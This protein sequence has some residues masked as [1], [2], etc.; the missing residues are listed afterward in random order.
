MYKGIH[1][2]LLELN[3]LQREGVDQTDSYSLLFGNNTRVVEMAK[4]NAM[5]I[6]LQKGRFYLSRKK[7]KK[8]DEYLVID[9][10]NG[11]VYKI[12][13]KFYTVKVVDDNIQ[14][15][16]NRT[17][18]EHF[19]IIESKLD[20]GNVRHLGINN[21]T[22]FSGDSSRGYRGVPAVRFEN[23]SADSIRVHWIIALIKWGILTLN[24]CVGNSPTHKLRHKVAHIKSKNNSIYNLQILKGTDTKKY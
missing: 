20:F 5:K 10:V 23:N 16:D 14:V 6:K 18:E 2:K 9:M 12:N 3:R 11:Q 1:S 13:S 22:Y 4:I 17:G 8:V 21:Y 24:L 7:S 15:I 19:L